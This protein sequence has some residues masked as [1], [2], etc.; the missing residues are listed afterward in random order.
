M[1]PLW[2]LVLV[3]GSFV[4]SYVVVG[5]VFYATVGTAE[6]F[7]L[8]D[9][10]LLQQRLEILMNGLMLPF[11][12]LWFGWPVAV[13]LFLNGSHGAVACV[14]PRVVSFCFIGMFAAMYMALT[15]TMYIGQGALFPP[16]LAV[17]VWAF[18]MFC[19][20]YIVWSA[21]RALVFVEE[22][23]KVG[24]DRRIGTFFL[25]YFLPFGIYFVQRRLQRVL[26]PQPSE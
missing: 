15:Y 12:M 16:I 21:A 25:F 3:T 13:S 9:V 7:E 5:V 2:A 4:M 17:V 18:G 23:R 22:G 19:P 14:K 24:I 1:R 20:L 10:E 6:P 11:G 8:S 26:T